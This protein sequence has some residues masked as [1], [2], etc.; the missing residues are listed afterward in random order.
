MGDAAGPILYRPIFHCPNVHLCVSPKKKKSYSFIE[1]IQ[2][3]VGFKY[4]FL[5]FFS[6]MF[7]ASTAPLRTVTF[8]S[9]TWHNLS[10]LLHKSCSVLLQRAGPSTLVSWGMS[11]TADCGYFNYQHLLHK[12]EA[13]TE[14][15]KK[16][17]Q[18]T[19]CRCP[20]PV[21]L[22]VFHVHFQLMTLAFGTCYVFFPAPV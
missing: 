9:C 14:T 6:L 1:V 20:K 4:Y 8:R 15:R 19:I 21:V 12:E 7:I 11:L 16:G 17:Q 13:E 22:L 10:Q 3:V 2:S 18:Q 5:F